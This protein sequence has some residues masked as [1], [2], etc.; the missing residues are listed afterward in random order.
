MHKGKVAKAES[1]TKK[2]SQSIATQASATFF[3][4]SRGS[5]ELWEKVRQVTGK[6]K[7]SSCPT[8]VTV[9]QLNPVSYTHLT[10]PTN[11][12]V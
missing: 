9:E 12:E 6:T 7:A 2:I 8:Q 5:K 1:L 3:S 10:L 11:R 4:C